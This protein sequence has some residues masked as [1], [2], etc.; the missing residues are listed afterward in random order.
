VDPFFPNQYFVVG[1]LQHYNSGVFSGKGFECSN[2]H[3]FQFSRQLSRD[4][5]SLR[6]SS[7][8]IKKMKPSKAIQVGL[9]RSAGG[10][11]FTP[12][13]DIIKIPSIEVARL[14]MFVVVLKEW[15][16][17]TNRLVIIPNKMQLKIG[18][19]IQQSSPT[20]N[21]FTV[22]ADD[23]Q[24]FLSCRTDMLANRRNWSEYSF[25]NCTGPIV[26]LADAIAFRN[27]LNQIFV[28]EMHRHRHKVMSS[29]RKD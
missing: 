3:H 22:G 23:H 28:D 18:E 12:C 4:Q 25:N 9:C 29:G 5:C 7:G 27:V 19:K 24:Y 15:I 26:T 6:K 10:L 8:K 16:D 20:K 11:I 21:I 1:S 13:S 2:S 14:T 17:F